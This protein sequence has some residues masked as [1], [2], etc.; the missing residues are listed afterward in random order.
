MEALVEALWDADITPKEK[1]LLKRIMLME[2]Q[3]EKMK[4]L[5]R[6]KDEELRTTQQ[7]LFHTKNFIARIYTYA[8]RF[9]LMIRIAA[10]ISGLTYLW[11]RV[12][13]LLTIRV[14][15]VIFLCWC[16]RQIAWKLGHDEQFKLR[17]GEWDEVEFKEGK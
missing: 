16:L 10:Y 15:T 5:L 9:I 3:T 11:Y 2:D 13:H 17:E 12:D 7:D 1:D 6:K 8:I 14:G 4:S